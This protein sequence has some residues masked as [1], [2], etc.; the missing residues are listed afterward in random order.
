MCD[1]QG[2][3]FAYGDVAVRA[4]RLVRLVLGSVHSGRQLR[5]PR[6]SAL[7]AVPRNPVGALAL[8][9][10]VV[11]ADGAGG[12]ARAVLEAPRLPARRRRG[13]AGGRHPACAAALQAQHRERLYGCLVVP[14]ACG[15]PAH[16]VKRGETRGVPV[17]RPGGCLGAVGASL[18]EQHGDAGVVPFR[19]AHERRHAG[20]LESDAG[21]GDEVDVRS[22]VQEGDG[23]HGAA[24]Q[25]EI[26]SKI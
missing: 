18:Q 14:Q 22:A 25:I 11:R 24:A 9:P 13:Q 1:V 15:V 12:A 8:R 21:R 20:A 16:D 2:H 19:G 17:G 6:L 3:V 7:R 4:S 23:Y 26:E 10:A 5:P